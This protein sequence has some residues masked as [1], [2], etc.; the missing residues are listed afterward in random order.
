VPTTTVLLSLI[1]LLTPPPGTATVELGGEVALAGADAP[2]YTQWRSYGVADGLP[3]DKVLCVLADGDEVWAGTEAGLAR[4]RD[5]EWSVFTPTEGLAY[6]VVT[7]LARSERTGDLWI[8]TLGGLSRWSGGRIDSFSQ[9]DSGLIND[10]VYAVEVI[11]GVVWVATAAG[12]SLYHPDQDAWELFNHENTV[13]HEPWCYGLTAAPGT[14]YVAV[15]GGGVVEHDLARGTWKAH[16]D[17][18]H[19][20]EIDLFRDD[21]L[22]HDVTSS[23]SWAD[24]VLWVGTYFGLS[25]YDGRSWRSW[26]EHDSEL[27]SNFINVVRARGRWAWIGTD[28]GLAV[29]DGERWIVY[30][31]EQDG[32][33][34]LAHDYVLG[35]DVQQDRIWVATAAGLSVASRAA[36]AVR[37]D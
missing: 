11:D 8:G 36:D 32:R 17:P 29:T 33:Q 31:R 22:V 5:G 37:G 6:P 35:L 9:L 25:R 3:A 16:R 13:M 27:P 21:G 10:V 7:A 30:R 1:V 28:A 24:G 14:A 34:G 23:V 12:V 2:V 4:L 26:L 15:W 20:M 18:D 19:E